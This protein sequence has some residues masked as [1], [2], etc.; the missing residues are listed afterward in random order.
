M[1]ALDLSVP[2]CPDTYIMRSKSEPSRCYIVS[3]WQSTMR[4]TD[5]EPPGR[6]WSLAR[7]GPA[8]SDDGPTTWMVSSKRKGNGTVFLVPVE[9]VR[10]WTYPFL[11]RFVRT[12]GPQLDLPEVGWTQVYIDRIYQGLY[13]RAALPFDPR[14]KDGG[15]GILRELLTVEGGRLIKVDT[16]FGEYLGRA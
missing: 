11:Y 6:E 10:D 4:R 8:T 5:A 16:R 12:H 2:G 9:D 13:L 15:S 3:R 14:K 7:V 1:S